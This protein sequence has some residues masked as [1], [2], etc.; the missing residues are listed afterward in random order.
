MIIDRVYGDYADVPDEE[1]QTDCVCNF[2]DYRVYN[3]IAEIERDMNHRDRRMAD[4]KNVVQTN[5]MRMF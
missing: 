1:F 3:N 2:K 4:F 5:L